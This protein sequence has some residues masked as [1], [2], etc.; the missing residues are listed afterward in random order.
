[1]RRVQQFFFNLYYDCLNGPV[2]KKSDPPPRKDPQVQ[3]FRENGTPSPNIMIYL[4]WGSIF[5]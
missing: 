4:D 2:T 5:L 1:M 3:I